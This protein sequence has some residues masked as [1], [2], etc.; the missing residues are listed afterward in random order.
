M[1][2]QLT[3]LY[4]RYSLSDMASNYLSEACRHGNPLSII[5][6]DIDYFKKINDKY[7][8]SIGDAVLIA[9]SQLLKNSCRN[10]DFAARFGGE[11]FVIL[12]PHCNLESAIQ[13]A[14]TL[15]QSIETMNPESIPVTA[16]FGVATLPLETTCQFDEL[17]NMADKAVYAAKAGG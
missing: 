1:T 5:V 17:F 10:E 13:K 14:E 8:H 3:S 6:T 16:S 12:L 2:D 4:N 15:R 9:V 11:E 7:G